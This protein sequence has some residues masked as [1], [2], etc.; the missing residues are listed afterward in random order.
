MKSLFYE[1][2]IERPAVFPMKQF[3]KQVKQFQSGEKLEKIQ[4]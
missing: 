3:L 2:V 4:S 1:K